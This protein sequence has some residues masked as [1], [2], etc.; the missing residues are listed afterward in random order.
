MLNQAIDWDKIKQIPGVGPAAISQLQSLGYRTYFDI[1]LNLP[2]RYE[3]H[4]RIIPM[5]DLKVGEHCL[6][7][8]RIE[9]VEW[10][11]GGKPR[12]TLV[13]HDESGS[14]RVTFFHF[15]ARQYQI[16]NNKAYIRCFGEVRHGMLGVEM[17]HPS[18]QAFNQWLTGDLETYLTPV[19]AGIGKIA[20]KI[21]RQIINWLLNAVSEIDEELLPASVRQYYHWPTLIKVLNYYHHKP[22][23]DTDLHEEVAFQR[24]CLEELLAFQLGLQKVRLLARRVSAFELSEDN[25]LGQQL[26]KQLPFELTNAQLRAWQE[27]ASDLTSSQP[28]MRLLQGDVGSGKTIVALLGALHAVS[29]G[30]QVALMAPT[31]VLAEQHYQ[32]I[33]NLVGVLSVKVVLLTGRLS[34]PERRKALQAV[35]NNEAQIVI[36]THALFQEDVKFNKLALIIIDEQHRFG[37]EQRMALRDKGQSQ[38]GNQPH[39]LI[40]TATP[41]PRTLCMS[42]YADLDSSI[43]NEMPPHRQPVLTRALPDHRR[44]DVIE[45]IK[46]RSQQGWQTY[47]VCP[48]IEASD[49]MP[50]Q[51]AESTYEWLSQQLAGMAGVA[52]IHGRLPAGQKQAVM[53]KFSRGDISVL[54]STTVIEVGVDVPNANLIVIENSP[55]FG[56]A[57]L[58]QLRGRV[59][60]GA[61]ASYCLLLYEAPLSDIASQRLDAMRQSSDGFYLAQKDLEIRGSG[62]ILGQRQTGDMRFRMAEL[63]REQAWLPTINSIAGKMLQNQP[64]QAQALIERWFPDASAYANI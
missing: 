30:C 6:V 22:S 2:R 29:Q 43:I 19:Y 9:Y 40:M 3:D 49:Q 47:W 64:E 1:V 61:Q 5:A 46:E 35:A 60:R 18:Y 15:S 55:R 23:V 4:T 56:L 7:Q 11:Q 52:M 48:L 8:G 28:M 27:I 31:E 37:V 62:E 51:A 38:S 24:L 32:T 26:L 13:M 42:L 54:V 33:S 36:G 17:I 25:P 59:G 39:Q 20:Q 45:R 34:A 16:L 41:I 63:V 21:W 58:H 10:V 14:L 12:L 44:Q 50:Q 53:E 57:Q